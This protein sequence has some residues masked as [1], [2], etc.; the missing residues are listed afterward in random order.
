MHNFHLYGHRT[1]MTSNVALNIALRIVHMTTAMPL[2]LFYYDINVN[3]PDDV[4]TRKETTC[5]KYFI[6]AVLDKVS[7]SQTSNAQR[8]TRY[9]YN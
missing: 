2:G 8:Y 7:A 9:C 5:C 4:K 6:H 3:K 1:R